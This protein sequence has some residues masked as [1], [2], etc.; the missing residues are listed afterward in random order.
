MCCMKVKKIYVSKLFI[1]LCMA[2]TYLILEDNMH[3]TEKITNP[4][5]NLSVFL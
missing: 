4:V 5:S 1:V 2:L 3:T